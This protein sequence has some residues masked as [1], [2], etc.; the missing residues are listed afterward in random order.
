MRNSL[1]SLLALFLGFAGVLGA[2]T[3]PLTLEEV[4][5]A[6]RFDDEQRAD[7]L[8]GKIVTRDFDEGSDKEMA[9]LLALKAPLPLSEAMEAWRDVRV[10]DADEDLLAV[11]RIEPDQDAMEALAKIAFTA[12]E[13]DEIRGLLEAEPGSDFNLSKEEIGR[14]TS[15]AKGVSTGGCDR[16]AACRSKVNAA[17]RTVL[18]ERLEAYRKGGLQAV[19]N[20]ARSRNKVADP[21][22]ELRLAA[23][24]MPL[25]RQRA[26]EIYRAWLEYPKAQ[27][28]GSHHQFLWLKRNVEGRPTF[29]LTHRAVYETEGALFSA[30]RHFYVGQFYNSLQMA[31]YTTSLGPDSLYL[32]LNRTST[33]LVGGFGS[34]AK[35][36]VGRSKVRKALV[37]TFER[38][39][40]DLQ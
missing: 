6:A 34:S 23:E 24:Q 16:D 40:A 29:V 26:P 27:P 11:G 3:P 30:E 32:L 15:L 36:M 19:A 7:L 9:I 2:D 13:G 5:A 37:G 10:L 17:Y 4:I 39:L 25:L 35:K 12:E 14:F 31:S 33:D 1:I 22:Q 38:L 28:E 20:Y 18:A 8:A 21:R